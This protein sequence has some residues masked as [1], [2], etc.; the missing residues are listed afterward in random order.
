FATRLMWMTRSLRSSRLSGSI[1]EVMFFM[2]SLNPGGSEIE[3]GLAGSVREGLDAAVV[4]VA[5]AVE[6]HLGDALVLASLGDGL[7]HELC[8][9]GLGLVV[10][11]GLQALAHRG[12]VDERDA[13]RVVDDLRVDVLGAAEDGEAGTLLVARDL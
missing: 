1:C 7:T 4:E 11:V 3:A 9:V 2:R 6:D 10:R 13:L 8:C 5:V 12:H